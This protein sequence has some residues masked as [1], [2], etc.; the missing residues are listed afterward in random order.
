MQ[1]SLPEVVPGHTSICLFEG[2]R[3]L[4]GCAMT[5]DSSS[6]KGCRRKDRADALFKPNAWIRISRDNTV[7]VIVGHSEMGQ[8]IVTALSQ[9]VAE[10]LEADWQTVRSEI[11]PADRRYK[12]PAAG[13][14]ITAGSTSVS[15]S[16][17][18]LRKAAAQARQMLVATA[19]QSW[20]VPV[21]ECRASLGKVFHIPSDRHLSYGE[22]VDRVVKSPKPWKPELKLHDRF[23]IVGRRIP[24]H[25]VPAKTLGTAVFGIDVQIP[26]LLVATVVH[27]PVIGAALESFDA[28]RAMKIPGVRRVFPI[29]N[30][31]AV[32]ASTFWEALRGANA[33]EVL[34]DEK[35]AVCVSSQDLWARW[36][37]LAAH[38]GRNLRNDGNALREIAR[39]TQI[40]E[41]S[42]ELP[43][44]AHA[45]MEPM[46]CT[47]HVKPDRCDVWAPTQTQGMAQFTAA[48]IARLPVSKVHIHT[49]FMGGAY[50]RRGPDLVSEAVTISKAIDGPAKV[51]W[52]RKEDMRNDFFRPASYHVMKASL[53]DRKLPAAWFHRIV[54]PPTFERFSEEAVAAVLPNWLPKSLRSFLAKPGKL[55]IKNFVTPKLA[56]EGAADIAYTIENV[57]VEYVRDDPGIPVGL[58]RAVDFSTNT[59]AVESFIDEI[60]ATSGHDPLDLR[61]ELLRKSPRLSSA[62]TMAA[63]AA[64][65]GTASTEGISRGVSVHDF[66]GTAV[67]TV[68]E[69]SLETGGRL[70]VHRVVCA[71]DCGIVINP[72]IVEAQIAGG[73]AFGLT[74]ALKSKVT[75]RNGRVEQTDFD[76]FPLLRM[77]EM[78]EVKV[79]IVPSSRPPSGIGEV[80]VPGIAPAVTNAIFSGTGTRIRRLPLDSNL[81]H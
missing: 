45:C 71:V 30:G 12:N 27:A 25:D 20:G 46:N 5:I 24:R 77:G 73:I 56:G 81:M 35:S 67:A 58:W 38:R 1:D 16:W 80:S 14:Q 3:L 60:A 39:A 13:S 28:S 22:L 36:K 50:G 8:G 63:D 68:A 69:V 26:G 64:G 43:F 37:D 7:T 10:E 52:T 51:V 17:Q 34:W 54:G 55:F 29:S 23:T 31:L 70:K 42:Y 19:A 53:D 75:I 66:H 41:A 33:I 79:I 9:I 49:T 76:S 57:R 40:V 6:R 11:A 48:R 72:G 15:S 47:A 61:L 21:S 2:L 65:W 32:V 78:P 44:Q 74:A 4:I 59:F 18:V 62:L